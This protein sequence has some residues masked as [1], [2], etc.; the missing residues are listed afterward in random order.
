MCSSAVKTRIVQ[1]VFA[2]VSTVIAA[3]L[4]EML[5]SFGGT[6]PPILLCLALLWAYVERSRDDRDSQTEKL[7]FFSA[8]WIPAAILAGA[9]EDA[10]SEFPT[11]CA[12]GFFILAGAAVGLLRQ[13][14]RMLQPSARGLVIAVAAAP[15]HELWLNMWG[16]VGDDP[17]GLV[18]FFASTLPAA[19]TGALLFWIFP[20]LI[21]L[22]GVNGSVKGER[23]A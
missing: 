12:T 9:F 4:Q 22:A 20:R 5:P 15:L 10:L 19:P 14:I 1:M 18:R 11:G 16:V 7:A 21:H 17:S 6:K 13:A 8:R 2:L 3:A 23:I